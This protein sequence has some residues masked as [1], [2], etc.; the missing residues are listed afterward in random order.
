M[1][2][3]EMTNPLHYMTRWVSNRRSEVNAHKFVNGERKEIGTV[4]VGTAED[5]RKYIGQKI[6]GLGMS[7]GRIVNMRSR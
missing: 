3:E 7:M 6:G 2:I 5:C 1:F 4:F